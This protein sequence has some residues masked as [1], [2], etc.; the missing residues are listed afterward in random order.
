MNDYL[1]IFYITIPKAFGFEAATLGKDAGLFK[2][3]SPQD[4]LG[5]DLVRTVKYVR[6]QYYGANNREVELNRG[7]S[8]S[9]RY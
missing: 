9:R 3:T 6:G 7:N 5:G 8:R 2:G 4:I 1:L